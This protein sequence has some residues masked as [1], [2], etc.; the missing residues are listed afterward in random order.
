[1]EPGREVPPSRP[2]LHPLVIPNTAWN[3]TPAGGLGCDECD[4]QSCPAR[5]Q[6]S[7]VSP[8]GSPLDMAQGAAGGR[9]VLCALPWVP[10]S[11]LPT[12]L[13]PPHTCAHALQGSSPCK[14]TRFDPFACD[15]EQNECT[16]LQ[17]CVAVLR[18]RCCLVSAGVPVG[19][20]GHQLHTAPASPPCLRA[21]LRMHI[22]QDSRLCNGQNR[23]FP[24]PSPLV[25]FFASV[26]GWVR[27]VSLLV[28]GVWVAA[29]P[30]PRRALAKGKTEQCHAGSHAPPFPGQPQT[31]KPLQAPRKQHRL[32]GRTR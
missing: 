13:L 5:L 29:D 1:M 4:M 20:A 25:R 7:N 11:S 30:L 10:G 32:L 19:C 21:G 12:P 23:S 14:T 15:T 31:C 28:V 27:G 24:R 9:P 3:A 6:P 26:C 22:K 17:P 18:A 2:V 16:P 8:L